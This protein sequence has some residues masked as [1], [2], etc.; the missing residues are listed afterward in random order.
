MAVQK[1]V[2]ALP[3][4]N[5]FVN[6]LK[7]SF[8]ACFFMV[9]GTENVFRSILLGQKQLKVTLLSVEIISTNMFIQYSFTVK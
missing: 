5:S 7:N 1:P 3:F 9:Y 8:Q 6:K 4:T 2:Y